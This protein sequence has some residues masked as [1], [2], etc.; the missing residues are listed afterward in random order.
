MIWSSGSHQLPVCGVGMGGR[1]VTGRGH[2]HSTSRG[3]FGWLSH[4][5]VIPSLCLLTRLS[6][7][8]KCIDPENKG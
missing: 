4:P 8:L 3:R 7:W 1:Q 5:A 6:F 2:L